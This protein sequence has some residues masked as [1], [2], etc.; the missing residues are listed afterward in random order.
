[1]HDHRA[2]EKL[3]FC[4]NLRNRRRREEATVFCRIPHPLLWRIVPT[5]HSGEEFL[6][7]FV[8]AKNGTLGRVCRDGVERNKRI[9]V[10][11]NMHDST[12]YAQYEHEAHAKH[13]G[14]GGG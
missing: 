7:P 13:M 9:Q 5:L 10:Q 2:V 1:M 14:R 12:H 4:R 3:V 6:A 11:G 8:L